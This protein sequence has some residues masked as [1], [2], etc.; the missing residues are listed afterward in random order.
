MNNEK[1][2]ILVLSD[3]PYAPSGVGIQTNYMVESL[4]ATGRYQFV[5]VAGAIKHEDYSPQKTDKWGDDLI[6]YPV[7]GYGNQEMI[8]SLIRTERPD[9]LWF[10]TDPRFFGWLWEIENEIRPLIPMVYY[11]VWDNFPAPI[12]NREYYQ[13]TDV[14]VAIS[15]L[16]NDIVKAVAPGV[17]RHYL[18]HTVPTEIFKRMPDSEVLK[19]KE[20]SFPNQAAAMEKTIFFWNGRNARRKQSGTTLVWFKEFLDKVGHDKAC[21]IMHTDPR[22]QHGQ[23]LERIIHDFD[24][25]DGQVLFSTEKIPPEALAA[26]YNIADCT[27]NI[28]DAEGFGLSAL[29]SLACETPVIVTMTGGLQEQVTD[30]EQ[31]FGVGIQP[32]SQAVIGSQSVPYIYEDRLNKDDFINALMEVYNMS[33]SERRETGKMGRAHVLKN[34]GYERYAEEWDSLLMEIHDKY[35]S[36]DNRTGYKTWDFTEVK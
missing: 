24:M 31:W 2:K 20:L 21:L 9:L 28:S 14:I 19:H 34:Y 27:I 17:E 11:H 36:W 4:L 18:P 26:V 15:K 33:E 35:G 25:T 3:H 10:M 32:S 16:T 22:D 5:C 8:R 23:D 1:I 6:I 12:Y 29:E 7:D 30:G 13:S